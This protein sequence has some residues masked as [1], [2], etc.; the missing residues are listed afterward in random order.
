MSWLELRDLAT[1]CYYSL[2]NVSGCSTKNKD[3]IECPSL[4]PAL[5][6]VPHDDSLPAPRPPETRR[7][8]GAD[9]DTTIHKPELE[10]DTDE[11]LACSEAHLLTPSELNDLVRDL[12]LSEAAGFLPVRIG[13]LLNFNFLSPQGEL[14]NMH[15]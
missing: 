7:I 5:S 13:L 3:S 4:P 14:G 8:E 1:D 15:F 11:L 12:R 2:T 10:I 9:E 6:P